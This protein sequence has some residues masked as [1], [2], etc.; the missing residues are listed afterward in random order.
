MKQNSFKHIVHNSFLVTP[1]KVNEEQ[2][3][4]ICNMLAAITELNDEMLVM[5]FDT[6]DFEKIIVRHF[7]VDIVGQALLDDWVHLYSYV[8]TQEG[9]DVELRLVAKKNSGT[10]EGDVLVNGSFVFAV[11]NGVEIQYSLT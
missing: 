5:L 2:A 8:H 9:D 3:L 4:A 7:S 10:K 6:L 1:D 11:K